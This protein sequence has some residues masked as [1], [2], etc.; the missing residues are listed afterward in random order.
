[1]FRPPMYAAGLN[2]ADPR[3][4]LFAAAGPPRF[5]GATE[6]AASQVGAPHSF[7]ADLDAVAA[8][9]PPMGAETVTAAVSALFPDMSHRAAGAVGALL[10]TEGASNRAD[11]LLMLRTR[12][13]EAM[14]CE[15]REF[16]ERHQLGRVGAGGASCSPAT[17]LAR[18]WPADRRHAF[19]SAWRASAAGSAGASLRS[20]RDRHG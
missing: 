16:A 2:S 6:A 9:L 7:P 3:A 5:G 12:G 18:A 13:G 19:R 4:R 17:G 8:Q 1:M 20:A 14:G 11:V 10:Q 15:H